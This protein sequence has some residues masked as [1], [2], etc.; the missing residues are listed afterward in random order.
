MADDVK[1]TFSADTSAV[2]NAIMDINR[3]GGGGG[4][5]PNGGLPT[6][7]APGGPI[8][9]RRGGKRMADWRDG[10][11]DVDTVPPKPPIPPLP[12][13]P[14]LP[15]GEES[16]TVGTKF[17]MAV[18]LMN[19]VGDV[20]SDAVDYAAKVKLA[21]LRSGVDVERIQKLTN[22]GMQQGI[23]FEEI[24][25]ALIEGNRRLGQGLVNGGGV[26]LGLSRLGVSMEQIRNK[27]VS[28]SEV[29]MKMADLYQQTGDDI[30][31]ANLGVSI[32]GSNFNAMI[33]MLKQG[34]EAIKA[35]GDES[36]VMSKDEIQS[37]ANFKRNI[38]GS[39]KMATYAGVIGAGI[40]SDILNTSS[41]Y[42][43]RTF[44]MDSDYN[45]KKDRAAARA[46]YGR[47]SGEGESIMDF[48]K[49]ELENYKEKAAEYEMENKGKK[50]ADSSED[51]RKLAQIIN[52][53]A[54]MAEASRK[55]GMPGFRSE[56]VAWATSLQAMGGGDV[57]SAMAQDPQAR[58]ADNTAAAL[59]ILERIA[60]HSDRSGDVRPV[61]L[62][63]TAND[64]AI[65]YGFPVM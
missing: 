42:M 31:M 34:R 6:L 10:A 3:M 46:Y 45:N 33:P 62:D 17:G 30:Q 7:P 60:M 13:K 38:E 29:L 64:A 35:L 55:S 57:L 52:G 26:Q 39:K 19:V 15:S 63:P 12:P 50:F 65:L 36:L 1:V 48:Y 24:T 59:P 16:K 18:Q 5:P 54:D 41:K 44:Q 2:S 27:S 61:S 14:P 21:S 20:V 43:F 51:N 9:P 49:A 23:S 53:L 40:A 56:Q 8:G 47:Y 11:I 4:R 28:T 22:A 32:F 25:G 37:A 58:I